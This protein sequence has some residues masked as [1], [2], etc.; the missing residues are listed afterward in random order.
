MVPVLRAQLGA[1]VS[2]TAR[3]LAEM[4]RRGY[5]LVDVV[6]RWIPFARVRRDLYNVGDV[7]CVGA[8]GIAL[9][10]C[11]S[12]SNV[13]ARVRKIAE[14]AALPVLQRAGIKVSVQGWRKNSKGRYVLREVE[15]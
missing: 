13:S 4:R 5:E 11:T 9:V 1:V 12:G 15:L 3:T 6:E 2:P 10:Q 14:S 7:L 8:P